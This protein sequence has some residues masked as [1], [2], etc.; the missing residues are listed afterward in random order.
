MLYVAIP[1]PEVVL[2]LLR[3]VVTGLTEPEAVADESQE[4]RRVTWEDS[5]DL[6]GS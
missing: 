5:S 2:G 1:V 4:K 6:F 3:F